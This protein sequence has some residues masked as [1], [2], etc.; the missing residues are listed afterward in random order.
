MPGSLCA[1]KCPGCGTVHEMR[2][3]AGTCH[4]H[5]Q[6]FAMEQWVCPSCLRIRSL[7]VSECCETERD[8]EEC[9]ATLLPW[10]G[11]VWFAPG[12]VGMRRECISGPCPVCG[13][14][15]TKR[16]STL[17]GLWD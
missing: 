5:G 8:C 1:P 6:P 3:G 17:F 10:A 15:I 9:G 2:T 12:E 11:E 4:E 13:T 14:T 7:A 16:D